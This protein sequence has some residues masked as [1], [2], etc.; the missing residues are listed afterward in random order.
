MNQNC[1]VSVERASEEC[2]LHLKMCFPPWEEQHERSLKHSEGCGRGSQSS[3]RNRVDAG[4]LPCDDGFFPSARGALLKGAKYTLWTVSNH[5]IVLLPFLSFC[6]LNTLDK[7]SG[8][9]NWKDVTLQKLKVLCQYHNTN[10]VRKWNNRVCA[11]T[12]CS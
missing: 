8:R 4:L 12:V 11:Y 1:L 5:K 7:N 9:Q 2:V 6:F 3:G 10:G